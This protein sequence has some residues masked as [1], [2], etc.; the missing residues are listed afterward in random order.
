[1][2]NFNQ[3]LS[4]RVT[5]TLEV[6]TAYNQRMKNNKITTAH[7]GLAKVAVRCSAVTFVVKIATSAKPRNVSCYYG[8]TI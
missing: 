5:T 4:L 8:K 1:V 2:I 6:I 7:S 3:K